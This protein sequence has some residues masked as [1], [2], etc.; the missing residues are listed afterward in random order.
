M[1]YPSYRAYHL[2]D[3]LS[4]PSDK[5]INT[6]SCETEN[7][8]MENTESNIVNDKECGN[9]EVL[10]KGESSSKAINSDTQ[11]ESFSSLSGERS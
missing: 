4:E 6:S 11:I 8:E 9:E 2:D 3:L 1:D 5:H 7:I 10:S